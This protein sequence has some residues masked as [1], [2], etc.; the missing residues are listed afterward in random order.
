MPPIPD[1]MTAAV[2]EGGKGPAEALKTAQ[3]ETPK[4]GPGE[5]LIRVAA[6][7]VN[8]PDIIQ[9]M[10]FYPAP[11]GSPDTLGLEVAGEVA[12][13]GDGADALEGRRSG[14]RAF[15][16]RRIRPILPGGRPA[17]LADSQKGS[18]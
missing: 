1:T 3:I 7:G 15:G 5:I 13:V 16:R 10:G 6:A 11:P 17:R 18:A 4:P 2:V 12:A 8:R 14:L 9:R